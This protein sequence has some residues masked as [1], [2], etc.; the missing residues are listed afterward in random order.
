MT[1]LQDRKR[2]VMAGL[3][4]GDALGAGYEF[5]PSRPGGRVTMKGG[6][7]FGWAPGE[8]TDDTS[9]AIPIAAAVAR[10]DDLMAPWVQD[11]LVRDWITWAET[12][13]DV[14]NQT[15]QVLSQAGGTAAGARG[16][17]GWFD[18]ASAGRSAGNGCLMRTAP[19]ALAYLDDRKGCALAADSIAS[20]THWDALA[21]EACVIWTEAVRSTVHYGSSPWVATIHDGPDALPIPRRRLWRGWID[22]AWCGQAPETWEGSNGYAPHA[23]FTAVAGI[24]RGRGNFA[25]S[26]RAVVRA[27]GDTDTTAAIAGALLGASVGLSGIPSKWLNLCHGWPGVWAL[28]LPTVLEH[29]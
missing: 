24:S 3:A 10:G 9:M 18:Q 13:P 22:E 12:A 5:G 7:P 4:V 25:Q 6:G 26:L 21:R 14:G 23:L 15:Q 11:R 29:R 27:G 2:G 20:L 1:T 8:W 17:S 19:I 16:A 28:D